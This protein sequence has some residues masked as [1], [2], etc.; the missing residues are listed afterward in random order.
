MLGLILGAGEAEIKETL[1]DF[2]GGHT[3]MKD[4]EITEILQ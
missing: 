2:L 3:L 1:L 4:T